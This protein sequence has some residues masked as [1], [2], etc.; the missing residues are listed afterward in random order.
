MLQQAK[1]ACTFMLRF[2]YKEVHGHLES[3]TRLPLGFLGFCLASFFTALI[4]G[5]QELNSHILLY[6]KTAYRKLCNVCTM[7]DSNDELR[8][9]GFLM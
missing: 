8:F 2:L 5:T 3:H 6:D 1:L 4:L 9:L 7:K